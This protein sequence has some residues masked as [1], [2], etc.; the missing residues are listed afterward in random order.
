M[1]AADVLDAQG[2]TILAADVR[3]F[4][5]HNSGQKWDLTASTFR[6]SLIIGAPCGIRTRV[7]ALRGP[8][9]RPLDEGS[10]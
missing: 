8:C 7:P 2:E 3:Y 10:T 6:K 9:P 4:A 1:K 5:R